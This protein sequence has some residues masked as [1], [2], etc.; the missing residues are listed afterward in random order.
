MSLT[1]LTVN[2]SSVN[3]LCG[4]HTVPEEQHF[5]VDWVHALK[6]SANSCYESWEIVTELIELRIIPGAVSNKLIGQLVTVVN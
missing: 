5:I 3:I 6:T 4:C 2:H 1:V